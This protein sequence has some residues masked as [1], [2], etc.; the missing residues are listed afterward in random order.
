M[1]SVFMQMMMIPAIICVAL[2]I[3]IVI[4]SR[5]KKKENKPMIGSVL[6]ASGIVFAVLSL[7]LSFAMNSF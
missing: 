1:D 6:I 3:I 7:V 2:G 5:N 4:A